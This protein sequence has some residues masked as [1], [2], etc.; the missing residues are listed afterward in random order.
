MILNLK[1]SKFPKAVWAI[2]RTKTAVHNVGQLK[3]HPRFC[4]VHSGP[5]LRDSSG[6]PMSEI[7]A[8]SIWKALDPCK[9]P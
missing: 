1:E 2:C 7:D 9:A 4:V 3:D 6:I 8:G 5:I